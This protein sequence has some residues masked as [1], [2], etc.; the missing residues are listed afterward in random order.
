MEYN[1]IVK[2]KFIERE[3]RFVARVELPDGEV[4]KAH[5]KNTG[6]CRELLLPGVDV[7]LEDHAGHMGNR[8]MR[9][10]LVAVRK[11]AEGG[12]ILLIN[13]DSQAPNKV[14]GEALAEGRIRL[15]GEEQWPTARIRLPGAEWVPVGQNTARRRLRPTHWRTCARWDSE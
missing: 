3:N 13:M 1:K 2:A 8:K 5:V 9:Y 11:A 14:V 10:S 7:Y 6:R 12:R 15:P 4:S